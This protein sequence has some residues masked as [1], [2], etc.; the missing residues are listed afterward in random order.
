[1]RSAFKMANSFYV[2]TQDDKGH[3]HHYRMTAQDVAD[4][5]PLDWDG[6]TLIRMD[7]P[8]FKF[9]QIISDESARKLWTAVH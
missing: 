3:K 9:S 8:G 1:M 2:T 6:E 7:Y 4:S 5:N